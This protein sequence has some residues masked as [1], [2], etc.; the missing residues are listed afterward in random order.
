[1]TSLPQEAGKLLIKLYYASPDT[2]NN[3][4]SFGYDCGDDKK[5][6]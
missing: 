3:H 6:S 2:T 5:K 1:M 4:L